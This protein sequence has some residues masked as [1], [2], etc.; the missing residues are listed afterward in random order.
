M[1]TDGG[2]ERFAITSP[3][4]RDESAI[5]GRPH[6]AAIGDEFSARAESYLMTERRIHVEE[7][8]LLRRFCGR[9]PPA[10]QAVLRGD[11][12]CVPSRRP[13]RALA[14]AASGQRLRGA[15]L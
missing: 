11:A 3:P 15:H 7:L 14:F 8:A 6:P 5:V 10:R 13:G 9:R 4:H 12:R 1:T 2:T